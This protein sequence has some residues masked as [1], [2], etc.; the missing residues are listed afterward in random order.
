MMY[1]YEDYIEQRLQDEAYNYL[2]QLGLTKSRMYTDEVKSYW[3]AYKNAYLAY[4]YG[5]DIAK[6]LSRSSIP[7]LYNGQFT[8]ET[9]NT[10]LMHD[11]NSKAGLLAAKKAKENPIPG[12]TPNQQMLST[13]ASDLSNNRLVTAVNNVRNLADFDNVFGVNKQNLST[14]IL[15]GGVKKNYTLPVNKTPK[16]KMGVQDILDR[17]YCNTT[18]NTVPMTKWEKF[19]DWAISNKAT[20]T[21]YPTSSDFYIDSRTDFSKARK[22]KNATVLDNY[23][24]LDPVIQQGLSDYGVTSDERGVTYNAK[25]KESKRFAKS[26]EL[27]NKLFKNYD[28]IASGKA[29]DIDIEYKTSFWDA[30]NNPSALDKYSSIQNAKLTNIHLDKHNNIRG[31][32][33]DNYNFE[34]R[35][36]G[37]TQESIKH[38]PNNFGNNMQNKGNLENYFINMEFSVK[39]PWYKRLARKFQKH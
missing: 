35:K 36:S 24:T 6:R 20:N 16:K 37:S 34:H 22:N 28:K 38:T 2:N 11:W 17:V 4:N 23:S 39:Y 14:P 21:L 15:T 33:I 26:K 32:L 27:R 9:L 5:E 25:S 3:N 13:L 29:G 8:K 18:D 30:I 31:N 12:M 19:L 1:R 10:M 7:E